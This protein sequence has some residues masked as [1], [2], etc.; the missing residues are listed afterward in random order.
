[1]PDYYKGKKV[2]FAEVNK[3]STYENLPEKL[4]NVLYFVNETKQI[5]KGSELYSDGDTVTGY[6]SFYEFPI[7]G[8]GKRLYI[9]V[10]T[11]NVYRWDL[12]EGRYVKLADGSEIDD[13]KYIY[14]G[15]ADG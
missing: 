13:I 14:G 12:A 10:S 3:L 15:N 6:N 7:L 2:R 1:M 9:D 8:R 4:D 5:Y 11:N